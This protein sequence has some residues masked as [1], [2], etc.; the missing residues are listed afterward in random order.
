MASDEWTIAGGAGQNRPAAGVRIGVYRIEA[1]LGKGGMGTVYYA[2]DTKLNRPVAIKVLSEEFADADA[3]RRFQREAQLASALNH[4]HLLTVYDAGEHGGRQYLVTEF[5]DGGTLKDWEKSAKRDWKDVVEL[6]TGVADGLAAAHATGIIHRDI[7]PANILVTKSG[8]AKLADFGLAKLTERTAADDVTVTMS[9]ITRPGVIIGTIAYMSPEQASGQKVD[10]RSDIFSFGVILYE[11]LAGVRP[12]RGASEL[13]VL[14]TIIHASP[15]P[16]G[17]ELPI[18]LRLI[19]EKA[20]EKDPE[21]RYQ[22]M[23]EMVVDLRRLVRTAENRKSVSPALKWIVAV[24]LVLAG[25][26]AAWR[27]WPLSGPAPIRSIAVL[28]LRN[29]SNDPSQE[30][31]SDGTTEA[32]ISNLAQIHA[33][34]VTSR[35]SVMHYKGTTLLVAQIG[36]EL[37]VD[38]IVEG[39]IQRSGNRVRITAQLVRTS[40]DTHVWANEYER[41]MADIL[42]LESEVARAIAHEIQA[43]LTPQESGRLSAVRSVRPEA[44]E[45]YLLGRDRLWRNHVDDLKQAI[46]YFERAIGL[47][48]DYAAAYAGVAQAWRDLIG[49]SPDAKERARMAALKALDLDSNDA[50]A[51]AVLGSL[52]SFGDLEWVEGETEFRRSLELNPDSLDACECY[53]NFLNTVGR[54]DEAIAAAEHAV[55]VNPLSSTAHGMYGMTLYYAGRNQE[56]APEFERSIQ[57]DEH[58][59]ASRIT[60]SFVYEKLGRVED[61]IAQ[62]Q[63][64]QFRSAA[65]LAIAYVAAGR[66]TEANKI[67]SELT[68][69][70]STP[71]SSGVASVYAALGDTDN[72]F[73]W[74]RKAVEQRQS[75]VRFSPLFETLRSDPRFKPVMAPLRIPDSRR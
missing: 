73:K 36:R 49:T 69:P 27:F 53:A 35:T 61:A 1:P 38:A 64:P 19:V 24:M 13:E 15:A 14:K 12:F 41:N 30:Y 17:S 58:N 54:F 57:L 75:A 40:N 51:H 3:R 48:P 22:S 32:I 74:L 6:L 18:A 44:Q 25:A 9:D 29:L 7:K 23:Q 8:Y 68:K 43:R 52:L 55:K 42:S 2:V 70:G 34:D 72:A 45:Q 39:S 20:L 67:L 16:L 4:P 71:Q 11:A 28:P 50:E 10:A 31:F 60:L 21:G 65:P 37:S 59:F 63:D 56:A 46:D 26:A 47:Q 33:L 66:P 62:L 5:V